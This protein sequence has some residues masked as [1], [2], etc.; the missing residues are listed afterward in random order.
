MISYI[1][2]TM[3]L[4]DFI[5]IEDKCICYTIDKILTTSPHL[6]IF[7]RYNFLPR[8]L[9]LLNG[10]LAIALLSLDTLR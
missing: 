5:I 4:G 1:D 10:V 6:S 7:R 9:S 8:V 3:F 2:I